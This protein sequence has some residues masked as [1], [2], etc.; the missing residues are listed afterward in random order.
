MKLLKN[1]TQITIVIMLLLIPCNIFAETGNSL[2]I[3]KCIISGKVSFP[4]GM[5]AAKE[6]RFT[7]MFSK[8]NN[9]YS[10]IEAKDFTIN[11][12]SNSV[13]YRLEVPADSEGY[14]KYCYDTDEN[15]F[16][17]NGFYSKKGTTFAFSKATKLKMQMK[18]RSNINLQFIKGKKLSGKVDIPYTYDHAAF[19]YYCNIIPMYDNGTPNNLNDDVPI[20]QSYN[21]HAEFDIH[22]KKNTEA[23]YSVIV[24]DIA[25]TYRFQYIMEFGAP[26]FGGC[27]FMWKGYYK[28]SDIVYNY[29]EADSVMVKGVHNDPINFSILKARKMQGKIILPDGVKVESEMG[30]MLMN[31]EDDREAYVTFSEGANSAEFTLYFQDWSRKHVIMLGYNTPLYYVGENALVKDKASAK[32]FDLS[33]GDLENVNI[34]LPENMVRNGT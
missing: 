28:K 25:A 23:S 26:C 30:I 33:K 21:N 8:D 13:N 22:N 24:P 32:V 34:Y 27:P 11:A 14:I 9:Q 18:S 12:G 5:K 15:N 10:F 2:P 7:I 29:N 17:Y 1:F 31:D 4:K 16:C 3:K 20:A 19:N 6:V